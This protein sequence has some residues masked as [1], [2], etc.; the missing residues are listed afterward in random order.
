MQRAIDGARRLLAC[1]R[2]TA[3]VGYTSLMLLLAVAAVAM[4]GHASG[5]AKAVRNASTTSPD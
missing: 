5:G 3:M 1:A 2:G 4:L